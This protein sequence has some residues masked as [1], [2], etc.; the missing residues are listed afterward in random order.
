MR[1]RRRYCEIAA[2]ANR[3]SR[4]PQGFRGGNGKH[5]FNEAAWNHDDNSRG[6][7]MGEIREICE[8]DRIIE[9]PDMTILRPMVLR[10]VLVEG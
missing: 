1:S 10:S 3:G 6:L 7:S 9:K 4:R 5:G 8:K 2:S